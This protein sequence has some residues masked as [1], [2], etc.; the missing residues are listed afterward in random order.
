MDY[1]TFTTD[2]RYT[3]GLGARDQTV[4]LKDANGNVVG[5]AGPPADPN[6]DQVY[7]ECLKVTINAGGRP[8][9]LLHPLRPDRGGRVDPRERAGRLEYDD[10]PGGADASRPVSASPR[11]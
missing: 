10:R 3:L 11:A 6:K 5:T 1:Y 8:D 9:R 2:G 7:I 4:E